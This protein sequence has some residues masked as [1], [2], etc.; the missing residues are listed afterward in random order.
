[1]RAIEFTKIINESLIE[2]SLQ[3]YVPRPKQVKEFFKP[4]NRVVN[5]I[6]TSTAIKQNNSYTSAWVEWCK[7]EMPQ[8]LNETGTLY[9][10]SSG[11]KILNINTDKDA[12]KVG[13]K[14][15]IKSP[16]PPPWRH[17]DNIDVFRWAK[18]FPWSEIAK[19][20]DGVHHT[21]TDRFSN[22]LM[23]MWDVEST[24]WFSTNH[25]QD[26]GEVKISL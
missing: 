11:A 17:L 14:Y 22:M 3:L 12:F 20:Y 26:M 2:G 18:D 19:D 5:T 13:E 1:M 8:W 7:T 4:D 25:L 23:N 10:V 6:W 9:K 24:V 21:P 16:S 15:G